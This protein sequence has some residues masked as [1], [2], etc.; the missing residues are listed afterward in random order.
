MLELAGGGGAVHHVMWSWFQLGPVSKYKMPLWSSHHTFVFH[1]L[2]GQRS[3][4]SCLEEAK[5]GKDLGRRR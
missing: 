2:T 4:S 5:E 1:R 3:S